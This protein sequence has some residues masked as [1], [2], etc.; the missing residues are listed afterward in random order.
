VTVSFRELDFGEVIQSDTSKQLATNS[1]TYS[2]TYFKR[3]KSTTD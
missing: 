2:L 3:H 1:L